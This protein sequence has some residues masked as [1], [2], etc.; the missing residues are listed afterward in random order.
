MKVQF[1][2]ETY[3]QGFI[4]DIQV[5]KS[6]NM[7]LM[8]RF[9]RVNSCTGLFVE[10]KKHKIRC[11]HVHDE[12][13]KLRFRDRAAGTY[14]ANTH[15]GRLLQEKPCSGPTSFLLTNILRHCLSRQV[16]EWH[17]YYQMLSG[18]G[19]CCD[20]GCVI[21]ILSILYFPERLISNNLARVTK[22]KKKKPIT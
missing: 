16:N 11:K 21:Q 6:M 9:V 5:H 12:A 3:S 10:K 4:R 22:K 15:Q 18:T 19:R 13:R 20:F 8:N 17:N 7:N 14:I 2:R 1:Q